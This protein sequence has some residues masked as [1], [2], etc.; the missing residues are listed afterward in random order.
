VI[1]FIE[2]VM[3]PCQ[4][5]SIK[6]LRLSISSVHIGNH[7]HIWQLPCG[8]SIKMTATYWYHVQWNRKTIIIPVLKVACPKRSYYCPTN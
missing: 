7:T 4:L 8:Q 2:K 3:A 5:K 1:L 6:V